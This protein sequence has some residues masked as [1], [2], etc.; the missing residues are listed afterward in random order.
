ML[1][2]TGIPSPPPFLVLAFPFLPS[3]KYPFFLFTNTAPEKANNFMVCED[4]NKPD[5]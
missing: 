2:K 5:L 4:V 3:R 1:R